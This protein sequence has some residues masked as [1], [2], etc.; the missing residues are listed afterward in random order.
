VH[1]ED[2]PGGCKLLPNGA[3][4]YGRIHLACS[5]AHQTISYGLGVWTNDSMHIVRMV[6]CSNE[7]TVEN[8]SAH[9][10]VSKAA[11][12]C[13]YFSSATSWHPNKL[14]LETNVAI[15]V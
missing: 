1:L 12:S 6:V 11:Q 14:V 5:K 8:C 15:Q 4:D 2:S 7:L 3:D 13:K 10:A 9:Y